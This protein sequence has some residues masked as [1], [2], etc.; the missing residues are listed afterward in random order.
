MLNLRKKANGD[1]E[2]V[3]SNAVLICQNDPRIAGSVAL[4][5][6]TLDPVCMKRIK[7]TKI[8]LPSRAL[9]PHEQKTG[10]IWEEAED[11]S[12][13][14]IASANKERGGYGSDLADHL[15]QKAVVAAGALNPFHP[16]KDF[17]EDCWEQWKAAGSPTGHMETLPQSYLGCPDT[18]FHRE[19]SR[20]YLLGM[21]SRIYRPGCK[22]D[23]M[24]IIR[25][26]TGGGKS[27]FLRNLVTDA[28]FSEFRVNMDDLGRIVEQ[29][30]GNWLMEVAEMAKARGDNN[31]LKDFLSAS[32]DTYRLAYAKRSVEFPRQSVMAA[33][34]N[35][36]DFLSDPTSVRR[37]WVWE[38]KYHELNR[39][40]QKALI[41]NRAMIWGET[42]QAF[43][44][45]TAA[46]PTGDM[47][48]GLESV[49]A[50]LEQWR[51]ADKNRKQTATE[52]V[53]E[54]IAEWLDHRVS[55]EETRNTVSDPLD[56]EFDDDGDTEGVRYYRNM[57]NA[58]MAYTY[59]YV[60]PTP[61]GP[62]Y[63]DALHPILLINFKVAP[64][65]FKVVGG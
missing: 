16:V 40:N 63:P 5:Q 50:I 7:S 22:F 41:A 4:N 2:P 29:M 62:N 33:T 8:K 60:R 49:E 44:D 52:V 43:L 20:K 53:A 51:I 1:L 13:A 56:A 14:I 9:L 39:I 12:I 42:Y 18:I 65:M 24:L 6:F 25:G 32:K 55:V 27:T 38:T 15:I 61:L 17:I 30:R 11:I 23:W 59:G 36:D 10:H 45:A 57:V 54:V 64:F 34:S 31:L 35:D 3:L 28:F 37:F 19:S 47:N 26:D 46:N 21:V 48:L 58:R